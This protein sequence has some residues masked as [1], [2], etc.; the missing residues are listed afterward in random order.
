VTKIH[1]TALISDRAQLGSGIEVGPYVIIEDDVVI[2]DDCKIL[3]RASIK[4]N[5]TIGNNNFFA[6]GAIIG[7]RPQ[8]TAAPDDVGTVVIGSNNT[9]R[10]NTTVHCGLRAGMVT[11]IGNNCLMMVNAHVGH[12]SQI[13]DRVILVNNSMIAGHV[14]VGERAYI[15]GGVGIHQFCRIGR[16]AMVGGTALIV[17]DVLPYV[18]VDGDTAKVVG[19]NTIGLK[20]NGY[21]PDDILDLKKAYRLLYRSGLPLAEIVAELKALY[22]TG[23]ASEFASFLANC[24]RGFI[25]ERRRMHAPALKLYQPSENDSERS[26]S[27]KLAG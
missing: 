15:S 19:L 2:G 5:T 7:G 4:K 24:K 1:P 18:T 17:Q 9:F 22:P 25:Q 23:A 11:T 12:D 16:C 14:I 26:E 13:A 8:H 20:R 6:E 27:K 3:A 10:E 21:S